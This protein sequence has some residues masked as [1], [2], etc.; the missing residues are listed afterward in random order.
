MQFYLVNRH[1]HREATRKWRGCRG[2]GASEA[3]PCPQ[4]AG[5]GGETFSDP[6]PR[7]FRIPVYSVRA[8]SA[9]LT[10]R[11]GRRAQSCWNENL[12][13]PSER[14]QHGPDAGE[15]CGRRRTK[16]A[17]SSPS[18]AG[19]SSQ[20]ASGEAPCHLAA[21]G[22]RGSG[23]SG[24]SLDLWSLPSPSHAHLP[25]EGSGPSAYWHTHLSVTGLGQ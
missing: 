25:P 22:G 5:A 19:S 16:E 2:H 12:A 23:G 13:C 7:R 24:P 17:H 4:Q 14:R 1:T 20:R 18:C 21:A 10:G 15:P 8:L 6:S 11:G 9:G 3:G